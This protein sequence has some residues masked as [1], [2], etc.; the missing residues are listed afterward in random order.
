MERRRL[1]LFAACWVVYS[2]C[3]PFPS[4]DSFWAVPVAESILLRGDT[5]IDEYVSRTPPAAT[6]TMECVPPHQPA[7]RFPKGS[8]PGRWYSYFPVS[9]S[10]F[11]LPVVAALKVSL[12]AI[13][14][15]PLDFGPFRHPVLRA[16]LAGD[17]FASN[18]VV[19]SLAA[20]LYAALAAALLYGLL[21]RFLPPRP[22]TAFALAFAFGTPMWSIASRGLWQHGPLLLLLLI[23]FDMLL[24]AR[25]GKP[26]IID[27]VSLP[28]AAAFTI[29]PTA[30]LWVAAIT[31][32]VAACYRNRLP[33]YLA[34]S[35]PVAAPWFAYH[36]LTRHSLLPLYFHTFADYSAA[37][38]SSGLAAQLFS[39]SRGLLVFSPFLL[40]PAVGF[41]IA[42]RRRWL[43]PLAPLAGV[44]VALHAILVAPWSPGH[45]YGSRY[46]AD[47]L[48]VFA[49]F[50]APA[51]D[52]WKALNAPRLRFALA[53]CFWACVA[54]SVL[55]HARGATASAVH[56]WN[57][58][59][60]NVDL[61][62]A[63]IWDWRDPQFLRG[64]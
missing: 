26:E 44:V 54:A 24:R 27:Y 36:L 6:Y 64:L 53:A 9:V 16:F 35:L 40:F 20:S 29:R 18:V 15:L 30:A 63:R 1:C 34:W 3:P 25:D 31:L 41:L 56:E 2:I 12:P 33:R 52:A 55:I 49:L 10:I 4:H 48:P 13:R 43:F 42:M 5:D 45:C 8:C 32:Y 14:Q 62:P 58:T 51:Y 37:A 57:S 60:A 11:A 21:R 28:L 17:L 19:Q 23:V 47:T 7:I 61:A 22:A 59:P 38:V 46:Y 50:L 39:P